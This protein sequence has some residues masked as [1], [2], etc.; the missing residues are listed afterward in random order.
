M[1]I[2][3]RRKDPIGDMI[4][5]SKLP[6]AIKRVG[7]DRYPFQV[8]EIVS[9]ITLELREMAATIVPDWKPKFVPGGFAGHC[10]NNYQQKWVITPSQEGKIV[11]IRKH[12]DGKWRDAGGAIYDLTEKPKHFYDFNF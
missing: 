6:Y 4:E 8:I 9:D 3:A 5:L 7:T 10:T 11:R 1:G 12:R 2:P